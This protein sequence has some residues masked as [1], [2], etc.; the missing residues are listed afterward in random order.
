MKEGLSVCTHDCTKPFKACV[1]VYKAVHSI[2]NQ[3]SKLPD[4]SGR[5]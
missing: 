5:L 2:L 1:L 4:H 3:Y